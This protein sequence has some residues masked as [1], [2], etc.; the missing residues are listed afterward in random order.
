MI[1]LQRLVRI[2]EVVDAAGCLNGQPTAKY[3]IPCI[4]EEFAPGS[5]QGSEF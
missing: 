5:F 2:G 1:G 3:T 4:F